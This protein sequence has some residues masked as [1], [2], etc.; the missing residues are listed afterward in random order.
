MEGDR[1]VCRPGAGAVPTAQD[2][3]TALNLLLGLPPQRGKTCT[4][5][6]PPKGVGGTASGSF[7]QVQLEGGGLTSSAPPL[8]PVGR[9]SFWGVVQT[10]PRSPRLPAPWEKCPPCLKGLAPPSPGGESPSL[11]SQ[12]LAAA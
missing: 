5:G 10:S 1:G 2:R 6:Q 8:Y 4:I 3:D 12:R 9:T 11:S 7:S